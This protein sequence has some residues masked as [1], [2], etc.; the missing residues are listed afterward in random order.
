MILKINRN[1]PTL[2]MTNIALFTYSIGLLMTLTA[3]DSSPRNPLAQQQNFICKSLIDGFLKA[4]NLGQYELQHFEP[5]IHHAV[6]QRNYIYHV[7]SGYR[8]KLNIPRQQK[9]QFQCKNDT[10]RYSVTL[11]N[12]ID[13][14]LYNIISLDLPPEKTIRTLTAFSIKTEE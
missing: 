1:H 12:P 13:Q 10:Q 9:L 5:A 3:C 11:L 14:R 6:T 4:E 8:M 7:S 2:K